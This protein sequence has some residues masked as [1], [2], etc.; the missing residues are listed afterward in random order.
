ME[1]GG[2]FILHIALPPPF[3]SCLFFIIIFTPLFL[4]CLSC[5]STHP[6]RKLLSNGLVLVGA[7]WTSKKRNRKNIKENRFV[8]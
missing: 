8:M 2:L 4:F 3:S 6:F 7:S 1:E 5:L